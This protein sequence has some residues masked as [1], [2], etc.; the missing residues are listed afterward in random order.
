MFLFSEYHIESTTKTLAEAKA[1]CNSL[2]QKLFE[3]KSFRANNEVNELAK[4]EALGSTWAIWIGIHDIINEG[5]FIYDSSNEAIVYENWNPGEP[6]NAG[7]G[8][9]CTEM[10]IDGGKWNDMPCTPK[11]PFACE[12]SGKSAS[13]GH[14]LRS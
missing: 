11:L 6:N 2:G 7:S 9:D 3:P 1:F 5:N 13:C 4:T 10:C 12:N 14:D 8:E